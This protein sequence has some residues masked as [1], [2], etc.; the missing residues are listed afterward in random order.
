VH[1]GAIAFRVLV[2]LVP[3]VLLGLGILG[4]LGLE[5][6]WTDSL[7]PEIRDRVS[8]PVFRAIDY[9]VRQIFRSN[10]LGLIAFAS[11][12]LLWELSRAVRAVMV[13]LNTIHDVKETRAAGRVFLTTLALALAIGVALIGSVL[14]VTVL[15]RL[16]VEGIGHVLLTVAA[17]LIAALL[18]AL[19]VGLLVRYAPAEHPSVG[20]AS[21]GSALVVGTWIVASLLFGW[22]AGSVANYETGVGTLTVFIFLTAYVLV[23]SSIF[24]VGVELDE[25]ARKESTS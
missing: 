18:L 8:E 3:L 20:W 23:C 13:A 21:A 24:L 12:L 1:T 2:A 6:V 19:V 22:W 10:A 5:D 14:T 4:A 17:W 9:S 16:G 25:L 7:A 15:P 11:L